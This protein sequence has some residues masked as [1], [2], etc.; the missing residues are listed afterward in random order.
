MNS[1]PTRPIKDFK[2]ND[3]ALLATEVYLKGKASG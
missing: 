2:K 1:V 3:L